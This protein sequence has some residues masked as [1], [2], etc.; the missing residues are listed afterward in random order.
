M[1][2]RVFGHFNDNFSAFAMTNTGTE[3]DGAYIPSDYLDRATEHKHTCDQQF[4]ART[5]Q[6][7]GLDPVPG[8]D[9]A[10]PGEVARDPG[11]PTIH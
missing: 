3:K 4:A 8:A 9:N 6:C 11:K 5:K 2:H 7:F 10:T 1:Q